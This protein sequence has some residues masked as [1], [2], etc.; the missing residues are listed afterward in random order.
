[1]KSDAQETVSCNPE[2]L[3]HLDPNLVS[4][5]IEHRFMNFGGERVMLETPNGKWP[6]SESRGRCVLRWRGLAGMDDH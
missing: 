5:R 4:S 6:A 3:F 2:A 1:M